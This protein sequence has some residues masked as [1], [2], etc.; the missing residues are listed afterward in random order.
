MVWM[1]WLAV[2]AGIFPLCE[3]WQTNRRTTL[4]DAIL[5][6]AG[7]WI[8]WGFALANP[9][10]DDAGYLALCFTGCAGVAVLGARRPQIFAWNFVV[11]GLAGVMTLPLLEGLVI[12]VHSFNLE[13]KIF[14]AGILTVALGNY[15]GTRFGA[16]AVA[17]GIACSAVY[18]RITYTAD[19]LNPFRSDVVSGGAAL[20][21]GLAPWLAWRARSPA[22]RDPLETEWFAFRDRFGFVWGSRVRDQFNAAMKN[23][24]LPISLGW[25]GRQP[26]DFPDARMIEESVVI[27]K[28]L[29]KRFAFEEMTSQME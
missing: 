18:V 5:W 1:G 20:V 7:A 26:A 13:R 16:A 29:A 19:G 4:R 23:A 2:A 17:A 12:Q 10:N 8:S 22:A 14:L 11:L 25:R 21:L 28:A 15:L 24:G 9:A 6:A 27:F 3:A